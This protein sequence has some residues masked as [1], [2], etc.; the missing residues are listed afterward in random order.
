M[1]GVSQQ[2]LS[3]TVIQGDD[4]FFD[5]RVGNITGAS[6][7]WYSNNVA[8][9]GAT[10]QTLTVAN[11]Q[12]AASGSKYKVT[13]T[14]PNNTVTSQEATLNVTTLTL[15]TTPQLVY[16]FDEPTQPPPGTQ[17]VGTAVVGSGGITNSQCL[18]LT[19]AAGQSGAFL[20]TDPAAGQPVYGFTARFKMFVGGGSVPPADGFA[21][22]FGNDAGNP[23][24]CVRFGE[25]SEE[26]GCR[27]REEKGQSRCQPRLVRHGRVR[28][29]GRSVE[30]D[31]GRYC[32]IIEQ[33]AQEATFGGLCRRSA[34]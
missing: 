18:Q 9:S 8:I 34:K 2:P 4:A 12:S 5:V 7:Q 24:L 31:S 17:N 23:T 21:F 29:E 25:W 11:V 28:H 6:Y 33:K 15:P 10:S 20:V 32:S 16:T 22:A 3:K 30:E 19:V 26:C 13:I 14:G 27:Q 1:V